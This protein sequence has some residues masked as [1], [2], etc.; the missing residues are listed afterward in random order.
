VFQNDEALEID[1]ESSCDVEYFENPNKTYSCCDIC[2]RM[3]QD[4]AALNQHIKLIH[5]TIQYC[6]YCNF[7]CTNRADIISHLSEEHLHHSY[8]CPYCHKILS[9]K[10]KF[11]YHQAHYHCDNFNCI[12]KMCGK[13][14]KHKISLS[15]HINEEH[16]DVNHNYYIRNDGYDDEPPSPS[17]PPDLSLAPEVCTVCTKLVCVCKRKPHDHVFQYYDRSL[18]HVCKICSKRFKTLEQLHFHLIKEHNELPF[19]CKLCDRKF[20]KRQSL[21]YHIKMRHTN[22][23]PFPCQFC[24]KSF[25]LSDNLKM[26][27]FNMH[28]NTI[29][30]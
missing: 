29:R 28:N 12:C 17:Y 9:S 26:H 5:D 8:P 14:L 27:L 3:F 24:N 16:W 7:T 18:K 23:M 19:S 1:E 11:K 10:H 4:K 15:A 2:R 22:V 30:Q 21:E 25:K 13:D 6:I 20:K